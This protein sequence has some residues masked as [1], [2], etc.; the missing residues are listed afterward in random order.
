MPMQPKFQVFKDKKKKEW[1]FRLKAGNGKIIC[2][3]EGYKTKDGADN[4]ILAVINDAPM[5]PV[6]YLK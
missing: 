1:R 6:E 5:A 2:Q 3:S 4:G